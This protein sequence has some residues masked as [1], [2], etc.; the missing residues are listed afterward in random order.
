VDVIVT[1]TEPLTAWKRGRETLSV[2]GHEESVLAAS[3]RLTYPFNLTGLPAISVPCGFDDE[4]MPIGMQIV[5]RPFDE[6]TVL[7]CAASVE[8]MS[9]PIRRPGLMQ[10]SLA[11]AA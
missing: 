6:P 2:D 10:A 5:G 8:L 7:R 11:Q 4:G 9:A 1:P 3:W